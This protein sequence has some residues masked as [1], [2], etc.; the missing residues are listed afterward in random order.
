[1]YKRLKKG[2]TADGDR[3][4][5]YVKG[6][7]EGPG[8]PPGHLASAA[9]AGWGFGLAGTSYASVVFAPSGAV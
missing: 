5:G 2:A 7:G 6:F 8:P 3:P 4:P 1:M 9:S